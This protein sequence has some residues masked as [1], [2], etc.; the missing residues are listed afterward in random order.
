[1]A[2]KWESKISVHAYRAL[3]SFDISRLIKPRITKQIEQP[4]VPDGDDESLLA[5]YGNR[6]EVDEEDGMSVLE[7]VYV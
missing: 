1:M 5:C 3:V 7:R 6:A 2:D 4:N